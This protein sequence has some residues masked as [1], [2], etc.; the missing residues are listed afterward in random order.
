MA[1]GVVNPPESAV[2]GPLGEARLIPTPEP[3][4]ARPDPPLPPGHLGDLTHEVGSSLG[5]HLLTHKM[6]S[7]PRLPLRV[8]GK[9]TR[10]APSECPAQGM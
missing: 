4:R 9:M 6:I 8:V 10:D 5:L 7:E 1:F 3:G 2:K